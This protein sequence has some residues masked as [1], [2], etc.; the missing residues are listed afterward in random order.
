MLGGFGDVRLV[1]VVLRV[2]VA[3]FA[4]LAAVAAAL[5]GIAA[6]VAAIIPTIV[7]AF[8]LAALAA[9]AAAIGRALA[10]PAIG[11]GHRRVED[12]G[13][14]GQTHKQGRRN[15]ESG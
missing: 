2:V 8:A 13:H 1:V 11:H 15:G 9:L 7:A 14:G 3:A 12:D 6:V 5:A 10:Q 4:G